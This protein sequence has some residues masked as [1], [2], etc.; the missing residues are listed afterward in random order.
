MQSID[1]DAFHALRATD[2]RALRLPEVAFVISAFDEQ[3]A[4]GPVLDALP[5]RVCGLSATAIVVVDGARDRTADEA[6]SRGAVV[7]DVPVRRGQGAALRLGYRIAREGGA[8]FIVTTDADGQYDPAD[9]EGVLEPVISGSADFVSGSRVLG[10]DETTDRVRKLGVRLFAS[11]I[12]LLTGHPI[13]DP[14]FGL[15]AMRAEV[16]AALDLREPQYQAAELL[17][18]VISRGFRAAERPATMRRRQASRTKKGHNM[19]YAVRFARA[20]GASWWRERLRA[21]REPGMR[22]R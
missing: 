17:V 7:C 12:G 22:A 16:T 14:A 3:G 2:S 4:I 6:R 10:R 5:R 11:A 18:A 20:V 8:R 13:T 15:R 1:D 21:A 19:L 9:A